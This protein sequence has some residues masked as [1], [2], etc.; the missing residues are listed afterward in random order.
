MGEP[1]GSTGC[2]EAGNR[3]PPPGSRSTTDLRG[4]RDET[5]A[6]SGTARSDPTIPQTSR[7]EWKRV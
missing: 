6:P 2:V 4:T 3:R 7:G 1:I 5:H